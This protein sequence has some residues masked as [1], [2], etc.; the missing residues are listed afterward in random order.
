MAF[1]FPGARKFR[2]T[3]Q[4]RGQQLEEATLLTMSPVLAAGNLKP[5]AEMEGKTCELRDVAPRLAA[6]AD[7][8]AVKAV[9]RVND[10]AAIPAY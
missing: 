4:S 3:V 9:V 6:V 8:S 1:I 5:W 10:P 7:R 2:K